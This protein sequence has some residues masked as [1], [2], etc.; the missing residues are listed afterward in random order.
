MAFRLTQILP[1]Y[2]TDD[3]QV[4][5]SGTLTFYEAGTSNLK[6][7]YLNPELT[8]QLSNPLTLMADGRT[9]DDIWGSGVYDVLVKNSLGTTLDTAENVQSSG[10]ELPDPTTGPN[11]F[12]QSNGTT[13]VLTPIIQVPDPSGE[14]D[15]EV[16]QVSSGTAVWGP[17]PTPD[18]FNGGDIFNAVTYNIR[19]KTQSVT[20]TATTTIDF[21]LGAVVLLAQAVDIASLVLT[22]FGSS[23]EAAIMTIIRTKDNS[24]TPRTINWGT[25]LFPGGTDPTL[26]QTANAVDVIAI[27]STNGTQFL[28]SA[29]A[30]FS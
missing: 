4:L 30:A 25:V 13:Y 26:T 29:N 18:D 8:I 23:G 1:Q 9:P 28:G 21:S 17:I 19:E 11:E 3:G 14:D 24:A 27:L 7:I 16:L 2:F 15:G 22:N 6:A 5:N 12:V 10:T 20:A